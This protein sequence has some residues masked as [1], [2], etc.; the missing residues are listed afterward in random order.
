MV[1]VAHCCSGVCLRDPA[2]HPNCSMWGF[3]AIPFFADFYVRQALPQLIGFITAELGSTP[4]EKAMLL[5][6]FF[7]GCESGS[8]HL[9]RLCSS[10]ALP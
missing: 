3:M 2:M 5:G 7:P 6:S 4:A 9:A 1:D 10:A 8:R